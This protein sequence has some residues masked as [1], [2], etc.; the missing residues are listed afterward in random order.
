MLVCS[1]CFLPIDSKPSRNGDVAAVQLP[2]ASIDK[3]GMDP[4][5]KTPTATGRFHVRI[6]QKSSDRIIAG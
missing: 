2:G 4:R 1:L 6:T 5:L 3:K